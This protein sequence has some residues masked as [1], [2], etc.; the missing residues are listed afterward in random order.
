MLSHYK[1]D[2]NLYIETNL[3]ALDILNYCKLLCL[4]Y[5]LDNDVYFMLKRH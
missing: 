1:I 3:S 2:N 4:H 5:G